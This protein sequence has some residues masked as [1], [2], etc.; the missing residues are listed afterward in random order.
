V[1]DVVSEGSD[2][3]SGLSDVSSDRLK[4]VVA[5]PKARSE[6]S[7]LASEASTVFAGA[8]TATPGPSDVVVGGSTLLSGAATASHRRACLVSGTPCQSVAVPE[9]IQACPEATPGGRETEHRA[10]DAT[11]GG[12][13]TNEG[14]VDSNERPRLV[15]K[16]RV[17][18]ASWLL[19]AALEVLCL[20]GCGQ[21]AVRVQAIAAGWGFTCAAVNGGAQCWGANNAGQLG[22]D[23]GNSLVPV[24]VP[25][26]GNGVQAVAAGYYYGCAVVDG[27]VQCWGSVYYPAAD[28]VVDDPL[29]TEVAGLGS[30]VQSIAGGWYH[31]CA[32]VNGGAQCWG[33]N[34]NGQLGN[35]SSVDSYMKAVAVEGLG[36]PGSGVQAIA[37]GEYHTCAVVNGGVQC[38]GA[39][40]FTGF[41][42]AP[43]GDNLA[44]VAVQ[45]LGSGVQAIAAGYEHTC[46]LVNGGVQCWGANGYGELGNGSDAGSDVPVAVQ[47]LGPGSGVQAIAAGGEATC[48]LVNGGVQCWG[49]NYGG[50]LGSA[51]GAWSSVPV[52][53]QGLGNPGSGVQA[54]SVGL[55]HACALL[56]GGV[57]CWG[58]SPGTSSATSNYSPVPV[59]PWAP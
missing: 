14:A 27:G 41:L 15:T 45:G 35:N 58:S 48:A 25:G 13:T 5:G 1:P 7:E 37:A 23:A 55:D 3:V 42:G 38:W 30:G 51:S 54:I 50:A 49:D 8:A 2:V 24:A 16:A 36:N 10:P 46:A 29:V 32:V 11:H 43:T 6:V 17:G 52:A 19:G 31:A 40:N 20:T 33:T 9:L 26:L 22:T 12:W 34:G 4:M 59:S 39:A 21:A 28:S 56:D 18:V 47:G 44:P 57:E 53:V